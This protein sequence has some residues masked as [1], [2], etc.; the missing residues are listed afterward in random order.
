MKKLLML[1][2]LCLAAAMILPVCAFAE[3]SADMPF[4]DVKADAWYYDNVKYVFENGI[5]KGTSD[6]EFSPDGTLTR[7]MCVTILHRAAGEPE[8]D[9]A[10]K[11]TD[12][13]AGEYYEKAVVWASQ[14]GIVKGRSENEF[15]PDGT[16]TRAEFATMLYRYLESAGK[17]LSET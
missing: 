8:A 4:R 12:V 14:N 6:T 1:I 9:G 16:I 10:L 13:K 7:A 17:T 2:S 15:V 3:Q 5:M 11:F